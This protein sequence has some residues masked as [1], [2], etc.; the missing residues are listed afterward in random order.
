MGT[1]LSLG[2]QKRWG[3]E[4]DQCVREKK[5]PSP[6]SKTRMKAFRQ[7]RIGRDSGLILL[8]D[9]EADLP[10]TPRGAWQTMTSTIEP[11]SWLWVS[12]LVSAFPPRLRQ[13]QLE[14]RNPLQ[15]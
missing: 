7:S 14:I 10:S 4:R 3:N 12:I 6:R 15:W 13:W 8:F 11:V 9:G 1:D 5:K 2:T